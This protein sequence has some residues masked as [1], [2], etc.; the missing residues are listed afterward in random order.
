MGGRERATE[1]LDGPLP[2]SPAFSFA[3]PFSVLVSSLLR[4][5]PL[6]SSSLHEENDRTWHYWGATRSESE[7]Q[8][9]YVPPSAFLYCYVFVRVSTHRASI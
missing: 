7:R 3:R 4:G 5:L 9:L 6:F 1:I 2:P 8:P